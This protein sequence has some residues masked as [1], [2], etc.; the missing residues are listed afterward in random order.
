M[1]ENI[2]LFED[3][4]KTTKNP[5]KHHPYRTGAEKRRAERKAREERGE[6]SDDD[7]NFYDPEEE[8]E[9]EAKETPIKK[10]KYYPY[11][12]AKEMREAEKRGDDLDIFDDDIES[13][14]KKTKAKKEKKAISPERKAH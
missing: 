13:E 12:T 14:P 5:N 9:K 8:K 6:N 1:T 7:F 4:T 11:K 2:D 10:S 3:T